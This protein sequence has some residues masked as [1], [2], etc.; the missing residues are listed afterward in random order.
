[1][2]KV[3]RTIEEMVAELFPKS[4]HVST[5]E[6]MERELDLSV[7]ADVF[8][9]IESDSQV[10]FVSGKAG[11]GKSTLIDCIR[12]KYNRQKNVVVLAPTGVAALNVKGQTIHS[13]F[14]FRVGPLNPE[15]YAKERRSRELYRKIDLLVIDE[16]SMVRADLLDTI[17]SFLRVN[18]PQ[19][20]EPFGGI[21]LLLVGDL[22]Q[23][24]PVTIDGDERDI[25]SEGGRWRCPHFFGAESLGD[26]TNFEYI[27]L[28]HIFR[29]SNREFIDML[30]NVREA[31]NI[32]EAILFLNKRCCC[33]KHFDRALTLTPNNRN[34]D[35]LNERKL[36]GLDG[37]CYCSTATYSGIFKKRSKNTLPA[38]YELR[39]KVGAQVMFVKND[40]DHRWVNGTIGIVKRVEQGVVTVEVMKA[41]VPHIYEVEKHNWEAHKYTFDQEERRIKLKRIGAYHQYP[42]M[43]AW[44]VTIHKSQGRTL[45]EVV[46]DTDCG[47]FANGQLYVALSRATSLEGIQLLRPL[48]RKDFL[49]DTKIVQ[50]YQMLKNND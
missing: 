45:D 27:E 7:Y 30:S 20:G 3:K 35:R 1:M 12:H 6:K 17:D 5:F 4:E 11:T 28:E 37:Q 18:G 47:C 9:K 26:V 33:D 39:L 36:S 19:T 41:G 34:A 42:L 22:F 43:L 49:C 24:P 13:F 21:K 16:I 8:D 32:S 2:T 29:Q 38:P 50:F 44:A 31:K 15:E 14:Q 23:L 25:F 46:I 48:N 40:K 10:I